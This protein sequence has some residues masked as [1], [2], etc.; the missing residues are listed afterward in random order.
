[1]RME[2]IREVNM[3]KIGAF[4]ITLVA[5]TMAASISQAQVTPG[6]KPPLPLSYHVLQNASP[7][8]LAKWGADLPPVEAPTGPRT[9]PFTPGPPSEFSPEGAPVG[10]FANIVNNPGV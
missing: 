8:A 1:M 9:Y 5:M 4:G 6:S 2:H 10:A 7:E 3:I